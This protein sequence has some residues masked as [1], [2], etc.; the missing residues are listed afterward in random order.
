MS[1]C[2]RREREKSDF[3]RIP[4]FR[5]VIYDWQ[6]FGYNIMIVILLITLN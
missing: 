1:E 6:E 5:V 3:W 4:H 2:M